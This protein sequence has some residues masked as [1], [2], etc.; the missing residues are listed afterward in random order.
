MHPCSD[1]LA[2]LPYLLAVSIFSPS[3]LLSALSSLGV[4]YRVPTAPVA[5]SYPCRVLNLLYP[6]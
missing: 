4:K 2:F 5:D 6:L 1:V 3:L